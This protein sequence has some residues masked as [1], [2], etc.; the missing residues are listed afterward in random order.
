VGVPLASRLNGLQADP[1]YRVIG[2]ITRA[3]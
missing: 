2:G 1:A 3:F